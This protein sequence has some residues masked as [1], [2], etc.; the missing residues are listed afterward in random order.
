[1]QEGAEK[2][3]EEGKPKTKTAGAMRSSSNPNTR[4]WTLTQYSRKT[5]KY[6]YERSAP[7]VHIFYNTLFLAPKSVKL[8][9]LSFSAGTGVTSPI[10]SHLL[11]S[12]LLLSP[13]FSPLTT[14]SHPS[15]MSDCCGKPKMNLSLGSWRRWW[16]SSER[17]FS[18]RGP[19][20]RSKVKVSMMCSHKSGRWRREGWMR[21]RDKLMRR[22]VNGAWSSTLLL[23]LWPGTWMDN[24][25]RRIVILRFLALRD[26][27]D[28]RWWGR[29]YLPKRYP[30]SYRCPI[31]HRFLI[32]EYPLKNICS[33]HKQLR[34][35][36]VIL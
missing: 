27:V 5:K 4:P 11:I 24:N 23:R 7:H 34:E 13:P 14:C 22:E 1:M 36:A 26:K 16:T 21:R 19:S 31:R 35:T 2:W 29:G 12:N 8:I 10:I 9:Q 25:R 32:S 28:Q 33:L 20:E 3:E 15:V 30:I 6:I 18:G 17:I